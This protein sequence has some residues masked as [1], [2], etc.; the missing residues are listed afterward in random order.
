VLQSTGF[1]DVI[2]TG[3]GAFAVTDADEAAAAMAEVRGDYARHSRAARELAREH[4]DA[5]RVMGRMLEVAGL[6]ARV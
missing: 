4:F 6:E 2:P 1:E 5:E 3:A